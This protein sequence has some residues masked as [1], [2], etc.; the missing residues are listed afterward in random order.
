MLRICDYCA[1]GEYHGYPPADAPD[2]EVGTVY[3]WCPKMRT[4]DKSLS[5]CREYDHGEN[6]RYDK[7]GRLMD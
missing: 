7:R 1:H 4:H 2:W 6:K 3:F 5:D